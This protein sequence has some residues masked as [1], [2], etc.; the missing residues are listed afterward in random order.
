MGRAIKKI[1][2][3]IAV[4]L[5]LEASVFL[6]WKQLP[7]ASVDMQ[8]VESTAPVQTDATIPTLAETAAP[9][10]P[11]EIETT[12][13]TTLPPETE[14]SRQTVDKVPQYDMND[15]PEEPYGNS[16]VAQEGSNMTALA[17]V[18]TYMTDYPYYPDEMADWLAHFL[19]GN[20]Q[21]LE[22]GSDLLQLTWKRAENIHK[23]LEAVRE[24]KIAIFLMTGNSMFTW[25]DHFIVVTG[26]ME[27]GKYTVMDPDV[28]HYS[29][30]S[31]QKYFEEGFSDKDLMRGYSC[32]WVYDKSS[33]PEEPYIYQ[34]EPP[35]PESRYPELELTEE[36]RHLLAKLICMEAASEPFDGQQAVAEVVLNR[37]A[38]GR[39]QSSIYNIIHAKG[40]FPTVPYLYKATPDYSQY[41]AIEQAQYGPY[42]LPKEVVFYAKFII[43]D[44]YWGQIGSHHFC[45]PY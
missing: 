40:Q 35:A 20:Y 10:E 6:L 16:T 5:L 25:K 19:G 36:E 12:P 22:Y 3:L 30:K 37:L 44:N 21:R 38:S 42:V 11:V 15:Y 26:M 4:L 43:N 13:P 9:T 2:I 14:P 7:I 39:F 24:G 17:M 8:S 18:A 33:M 1:C 32:G 34:P 41:K 27:N 23:S 31:L 29:N 28:S 45:Y